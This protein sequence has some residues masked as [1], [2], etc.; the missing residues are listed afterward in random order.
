[1]ITKRF[2]FLLL[3][4]LSFAAGHAQGGYDPENPGDPN[5]YRKLTL[6]A[7]PKTGGSVSNSEGSTQVSVGQEVT[8]YASAHSYYDFVHWLKDGEVVSTNTYYTFTMP[9]SNVVMTAVFVRNYDPES[10]S[11]PQE[12]IPTHKVIL[13]ASPGMGG[14]FNSSAFKLEE[15]DSANVYAYPYD[16]YRFQEWQLNGV[17]VSRKNPMM[18]KM[19]EKDLHYTATFTYDPELPSDPGANAFNSATG[20][21]VIDHFKIGY[22]SDAIST[23]LGS[24]YEYSQIQSLTVAG[25]MENYDFGFTYNLSSCTKID[26]S[27][28]SGYD[29]IPSYAFESASSLTE[30]LL[31]SC[32]NSIGRYAFSGCDNLSILTCYAVVPPTLSSNALSGLSKDV[33][34]KVPAQSVDLYKNAEGWKGYTILPA[35]NELYSLTVSLPSDA[36]DGRYKNMSLELL[37]TTNNQRTKYLITDKV[38]YIFYN[39]LSSTSYIVSVKNSKDEVLGELT[40]IDIVDKDKQVS[41]ESLR[42]PMTV[43]LD[44]LSPNGTNLT[45]SVTVKWYDKDGGMLAQGAN[46]ANVLEGSEIS[47]LVN[48]PQEYLLLYAVPTQQNYIVSNQSNEL[49]LTLET[50]S[51]TTLTGKVLDTDGKPVSFAVLTISQCANGAYI[52]STNTTTDTEGHYEI[53][54]PNVSL[55]VNVS[56]NGYVNQTKNLQQATDGIG[57]ITMEKYTGLKIDASYTFQESVTVGE[58]A[59]VTNYYS[60]DS[61]IAYRVED[62]SGNELAD[63]VYQGSLIILPST[64]ETDTELQVTAYSKN[65]KFKEVSQSVTLDGKT[66]YVTFSIVEYGGISARCTNDAYGCIC[67]LYNADGVQ[68]GKTSFSDS[69]ASFSTLPDGNYTMVSMKKSS[70][71]NGVLNLSALE[72]AGLAQG[73][74]YLMN[75]VSVQSG[76]ISEIA[77][78]EIPELD[79]TKLYYTAS[80]GTYFMPNKTQITIG[81]YLT[82][83]S[84]VTLKDEY[85][86]KIDAATLVV[87]IP[88]SCNFVDNSVISGNGA[89]DYSIDGN[90]ISIPMKKI[91]DLI[92]FCIIPTEGGECRP[93]AFVQLVVDNQE[94]MQPIGSAYFEALNFSLD[95]PTKASNPTIAIRGKATSD[96]EVLVYDN[97][98]FVGKTYSSF[99][100]DWSMKL[101]LVKPYTHSLHDIYG[102]IVTK[103]GK[104]LLTETKTVDYDQSYV[105]L[106][107]ITMVYNGSSIVFDQLNGKT[108]ANS[109]SYVPGTDN[110]TFIADFT[111]ND[112]AKTSSVNIKVLDSDGSIRTLEA[113]YNAPTKNWVATTK[114]SDSGKLPVNATAEFEL[115]VTESGFCEEAYNDQIASLANGVNHMIDVF[116]T[117]VSLTTTIDEEGYFEGILS[118]R[119]QNMNYSIKYL[120]YDS[121]YNQVMYEKQFMVSRID[122]DKIC[123][124]IET[125]DTITECIMVD[126]KEKMAVLF[127]L[128]DADIYSKTKENIRI[129]RQI[130][131]PHGWAAYGWRA[132]YY[133][134]S[135]FAKGLGW[136]GNVMDFMGV[137]DYLNVRGDLSM[138][139]DN[140]VKYADDFSKRNENITAL[141][142]A[143]CADGTSRLY[144]YQ[145]RMAMDEQGYLISW[146]SN[147]D[148]KYENYISQ[149][150]NAFLW[151]MAGF[152]A[153]CGVGKLIGKAVKFLNRGGRALTNWYRRWVNRE[154]YHTVAEDGITNAVNIAYNG[155]SQVIGEV[156]HPAF[157]DFNGV[158]D[159]LWNWS[160]E[161]AL[162]IT[163][164]YLELENKIKRAYKECPKREEPEDN[165]NKNDGGNNNFPTPPTVPSVD[166]SGYVYEAVPSNRIKGVTATAYYMQQTEDMYGDIT[167]TPSIWDAVPFGQENPLLTDEKGMYAWDVPQGMWQVKFEKD[168]YETTQSEWLPV[169]PPQLEV[170]IAM[171]QAKQPEVKNVHAYN[172]GVTIEFDK[173]M[174]P[175]TL[176]YGNITVSQ[177]GKVVE[178]IISFTDKESNAS[179]DSYCSKVEFVP[180]SE[181]A[182]GEATLF[183]SKAVKSYANINMSE[184]FTQTFTI[185]PRIT[186]ISVSDTIDVP[187]GSTVSIEASVLPLAASQNKTVT[188]ENL[189]SAIAS[190]SA[191]TAEVSDK[192]T[193][194]F[195]IEG[196]IIGVGSAIISVDGYDCSKKI[197][198]NVTEAMAKTAAPTASIASG[199]EVEKGTQVTLSTATE[200]ATIYYT[201]DGSCPCDPATA[202]VYDGTP[203]TINETVTIKAMAAKEGMYESYV[204]EFTYTV[205]GTT[206]VKD[207]SLNDDLKI[208]P[209]PMRDKLNITAGGRIINSVTIVSTNGV[210]VLTANVSAQEAHLNVGNIPVGTYILNILTDGNVFSRKVMKVDE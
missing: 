111:D 208:A 142:N 17:L 186:E 123:W 175:S 172:D 65:N 59:E 149:Y 102:E 202:Q 12:A 80:D 190:V 139:F 176:T 35:D 144:T 92:R 125:S 171:T 112:T 96:S 76:V 178:G 75:T 169:P 201:T 189:C 11:D 10:P 147:F 203:I 146:Y 9:D 116:D 130:N 68:V 114:Y 157:Y 33:V 24:N 56:A 54:V 209:L 26:L 6:T 30:L 14:Y 160:S 47:Y 1:M 2:L 25:V 155:G 32:I 79:E 162:K 43:S 205:S 210:T 88:S 173:F 153:S 191:D 197:T 127:T 161:E 42:Q 87:D 5:P 60:D 195:D 183:V 105:D 95:V 71:F 120:D 198:I 179:G 204:A 140:R 66:S 132:E 133:D 152:A 18:V 83:K 156:V 174:L 38:E 177:N 181:L 73:T 167:E 151:N 134:G 41:F 16:G 64:I 100:G 104:R 72:N 196:L 48:L 89:L 49:T 165:P 194:Y 15:G 207:L 185:E 135:L 94:V 143:T 126:F 106:S 187:C 182:N 98:T 108:S 128:R 82:L 84:K 50:L 103:D 28:T 154:A 159:A 74:D 3:A 91:G 129:C 109:Y 137:L 70:L 188:I 77:V 51:K 97:E 67:I 20:E 107:K 22:L 119:D 37:N 57:D 23:L 170:N 138:M 136:I 40:A 141:Y 110:F 168:G 200:G 61:N 86:D 164:S 193:I 58:T 85:Y 206:T 184:D 163:K 199:T 115:S 46:V 101:S 158:K 34:I 180:K 36:A 150:I 145:K 148:E 45:D 166:P 121:V 192:G 62:A 90:R 27:R 19:G 4:V 131:N 44:V 81:N 78:S 113:Q 7:T 52:N 39:L 13:T 31:P 8:C 63:C 69:I 21:M 29:E 117:D 93:N 53:E 122:D 124:R 99:S 118:Y 55:K